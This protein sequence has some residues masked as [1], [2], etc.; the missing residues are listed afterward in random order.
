MAAEGAT[1]ES[2]Y[3]YSDCIVLSNDTTRAV[4]CPAAG[5]RILEY[6]RNGK[7]VLYLPP[8]DEGWTYS[9]NPKDRGNMTAGRFDIGP[10]RMVKRGPLL[11]AG[12]WNA[13]ITGARTAT[14]T[15][16]VDPKSGVHLTRRFHLAGGSS[17]LS[18]TQTIHNDSD[19]PVNLCHWSRTFAVGNGIAVVPRSKLGRFPNGWAMY[20][21]GASVLF[22]PEDP[23][24]VVGQSAVVIKGPPKFSKLGFDH[25]SDWMAYL[26]PTD[27]LF[28]K[29]Y[30]TYRDQHY[31]EMAG[32]TASV[33]YPNNRD[34]VEV[35]PIGPAHFLKPG[36]SGAFTEEW[37][38]LE[39]PF[40]ADRDVD[41]D[42][43]RDKV[44][45]NTKPPK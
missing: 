30:R 7:N 20:E 31:N 34:T 3:G 37:W 15:S 44:L 21:N 6:S 1:I 35:E 32:L 17:H 24:V 45:E 8:G 5:G 10:E 25:Y 11:W 4:L 36:E 41:V 9:G 14:L 13:A 27:Q 38:L 26:A 12:R 39:H 28:V 23:N 29:R 2:Y 19:Q 43:L 16:Q 40:P 33:W 18:V 42:K 22:R